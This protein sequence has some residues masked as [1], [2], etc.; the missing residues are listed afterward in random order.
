LK[1]VWRRQE[2]REGRRAMGRDPSYQLSIGLDDYP[3]LVGILFMIMR[4]PI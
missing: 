2:E 1:D 3:K 4:K